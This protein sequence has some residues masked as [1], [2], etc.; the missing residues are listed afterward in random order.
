MAWLSQASLSIRFP[1]FY[2]L[3]LWQ[4]NRRSLRRL[5][6]STPCVVSAGVNCAGAL[7][8]CIANLAFVVSAFVTLLNGD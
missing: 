3:L 1:N 4:E 2:R 5:D 6:Q 7:V 8:G